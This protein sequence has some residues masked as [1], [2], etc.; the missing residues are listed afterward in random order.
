MVTREPASDEVADA[1]SIPPG[2]EVVIRF[3]VMRAEGEPTLC[4][5]TS[6]FPT[7]VTD[8]AP[9]LANPQISGMPRW[10]R[11]AFGDTYS[12]DL[13]DAR[14]ATEDEARLLEVEPG[15]PVVFTKGVTRDQQHRTLHFI[16]VVT[17]SGRMP[18][19]YRYGA[20]PAEDAPAGGQPAEGGH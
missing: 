3:R 7:W 11:D 17:A 19:H 16:Y 15:A 14:A 18:F 5:A 6:Y 1:L 2:T 9:N 12:E 10:L 13:V 20:V 8:A 4:L